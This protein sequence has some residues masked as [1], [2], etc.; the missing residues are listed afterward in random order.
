MRP[1]DE[2]DL[3]AHSRFLRGLAG[4]LVADPASADDAV[5]E[6]WLAALRRR[7]D[8]DRPLRPW[9]ARVVVNAVRKLGRGRARRAARER[10]A[11]RPEALPDARTLR[12]REQRLR[13]LLDAVLALPERERE[14]V[15]LRW[16][17]A[18]PP[19]EIAARLRMPVELVYARL[20]RALALLRERLDAQHGGERSTWALGL[21][22]VLGLPRE[23]LPTALTAGSAAAGTAAGTTASATALP[24]LAGSLL[25]SSSTVFAVAVSLAVGAGAGWL[26]G[27]RQGTDDAPRGDRAQAPPADATKPVAVPGEPAK[28]E[29]AGHDAE[30]K[31][32][33]VRQELAEARAALAARDK[34]LADAQQQVQALTPKPLDASAFRFGLPAATPGFDQTDWSK[35]A[36]HVIALSKAMPTVK[37]DLLGGKLTAVSIEALQKHNTPLVELALRLAKDLGGDTPNDAYTH[38]AAIANLIRSVLQTAGD[39]LT[40]AQEHGIVALGK[41]WSAEAERLK[42]AP[43]AEA[44]ALERIVAEVAAKER[45]L[46]GL[47]ELLTPAQRAVLW[48]PETENRIGLDIFSPGLI[49]QMREDGTHT[50]P[51]ALPAHAVAKLLGLADLESVDAEPFVYFGQ[52][53]FD[54]VAGAK[55]PRTA[56]DPEVMFPTLAAVQAWAQAQLRATRGIL[57]SSKLT[58]EQAAALRGV[59][60]LVQLQVL[61]TP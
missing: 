50:D 22:G 5:Q 59:G 43:A 24:P 53:W 32:A 29:L 30:Q 35:V 31:L 11:A 15:L 33:A 34:A 13:G 14:A 8:A 51:A 18:L 21:V 1:F 45:F 39:P 3:A 2:Q 10:A 56:K 47:K 25:M 48:Q 12:E 44:L 46:A 42:A 57:E 60:T 38:P 27:S 40:S 9:L 16:Y 55:E 17:E 36:P 58:P 4:S 54:E 28:P 7:P 37:Q 52:R 49:Y 41:T 61:K 19:R 26:L 20:K 6:A 23:L